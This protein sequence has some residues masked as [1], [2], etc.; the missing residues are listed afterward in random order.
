MIAVDDAPGGGARFT[1]RLPQAAE[2]VQTE[3]PRPGA[4]QSVRGRVLVVDDERDI[5]DVLME[6]LTR[7]GLE[8]TVARDGMEGLL[9]LEEGPCDLVITDLRMPGMD[10]AGLLA[11][12][13]ER[14]PA[15]RPPVIVLTGDVLSWSRARPAFDPPPLVIEKPFD[16]A[17]L[18]QAVREALARRA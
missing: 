14:P 7:Q 6:I 3:A 5:T 13:A 11:R 8:V 16:P 12:L 4:P 17:A 15:L 2:A 10:G 1:V 9:R 18:S